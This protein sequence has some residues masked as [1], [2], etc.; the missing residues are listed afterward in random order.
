M[1]RPIRLLH[2]SDLHASQFVTLEMIEHAV[3][4]GLSQRPDVICLTGDY[5]SY[6]D[7]PDPG[8]YARILRRLSAAAPTYTVLGNH[9]GGS[10]A[11]TIGGF[12]DHDY[13][14]RVLE[15]A[16]ITLLHNRSVAATVKGQDLWLVGAGDCW[17]HEMRGQQAFQGVPGQESP[18]LLLSHNPDT[19]DFLCAHPWD[20]MLSG[21]THGGQII[22]PAY[23]P[24]FVPVKDRRYVAGLKSWGSRQIHVSRGVGNLA[25]VRFNCRPEVSLLELSPERRS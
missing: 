19:K 17:A 16:G 15:N 6:Q 20:L 1:Q 25:S 21:H 12:S 4:Q 8:A 24:P 5:I 9:D 10:W 7:V 22:V 18:V 13:V 11:A 14:L 2:L 23:G 3:A